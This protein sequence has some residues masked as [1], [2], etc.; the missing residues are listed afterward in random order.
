MF[1]LRRKEE[2]DGKGNSAHAN[3][4]ILMELSWKFHSTSSYVSKATGLEM[5]SFSWHISTQNKIIVLFLR[6]MAAEWETSIFCH[7]CIEEIK[8][9][10]SLK[11]TTYEEK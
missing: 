11:I 1:T 9:A 3:Y 7:K 10:K 4:L 5:S 2:E 6:R 8:I